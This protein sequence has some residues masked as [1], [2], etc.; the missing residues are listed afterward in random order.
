M[1]ET[2][3]KGYPKGFWV[4]GTTEI[5]ERLA[6]YLG[7]SLILIFVTAS[8][9]TGGLGLSK[10]QGATMQSL[11]TA[12]AYLGPLLGGVIADRYIGGRYTTPI[13]MAIVG[14]GYWCGSIAKSPAMVYVMI[15]CVSIGL[16]LYKTGALIGRIITDKDQVD[17]AFSIRY[18]LVNT[19][20]FIGTFL[21]GILY[22]DVFA[23]NG[24]LGFAP[25]FKLAAISMW[26][27]AIW[28][29]VLGNRYMGEVGKKPFKL[30][31]TAEELERERAAQKE[32]SKKEPLTKVEK[33][34]IAA[35]F[36][37]AGFSVIFW[38]FW[39]LA[40]LP[41]YYYW[42]E[43]MNWVVAGY[44]VPTTWFDA[45][46][47]MFCVILG[48]I[49]A[50]L[51]RK[52]ADRPQGDMSLFKK[53]G[54]GIGILGVSYL[55]FAVLDIARG[56]G[57]ISVVW[58]LGFAFLLTL[59]EMFFSPL[60]HAFI[61]KYSPSRYLST[62]MAVWGIATFISSLLYGPIFSATF[63]GGFKFTSVCIGIAIIAFISAVVLFVLDKR[64]SK[65]VE[66]DEEA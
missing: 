30:E 12:F 11:L 2:K 34:R 61:S 15:L 5:F 1:G 8:V 6:Y 44:E 47:S 45:A 43:H 53:T 59:G 51:W 60:G 63:E 39:N 35:I 54:V 19:G 56:G 20:A 65:L 27:G 41:V 4:C 36:L 25:C 57:K 33:K 48:P 21:V 49:T 10:S 9:A 50:M 22:K 55:F 24:V 18:T 32:A 66:E 28:F 13:G 14:V 52:L 58:L 62:M 3:K 17:S 37:V 64:L 42:T 31:K 16:G 7:R 40:Y 29:F 38:I 46:N 26:A 23:K